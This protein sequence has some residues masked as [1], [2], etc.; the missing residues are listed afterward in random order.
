MKSKKPTVAIVLLT[1]NEAQKLDQLLPTLKFAD[2][3]ILIDDYSSDDTEKIAK[4]YKA[5][6]YKR[7]LDN[8]F[9][10]QRN[11]GLQVAR[12]DWVLFI[13]PDETV[14][15]N[16]ANEIL[17]AI[18]VKTPLSGYQIR[19]VDIFLNK[20]LLHGET[21]N[22]W[23]TR[24]GKRS[25]GLWE[26]QVHEIWQLPDV[27]RLHN[28]IVHQAHKNFQ[29]LLHKVRRYARIEADYRLKNGEDFSL[30]EY[31]SYPIGKWLQNYIWKLGFLDGW[32]GFLMALGMSYHS[33]LCRRNMY[34]QKYGKF[35]TNQPLALMWRWTLL[36]IVI[37]LALGQIGRI[38]L[39]PQ[40]AGYYFEALMVLQMFILLVYI[41][42]NK[43]VFLWPVWAKPL[44][45]LLIVMALSLLI[46]IPSLGDKTFY[47]GLYA[48][49][50]G[51]YT[52]WWL[53][54]WFAKEWGIIAFPYRRI[55][56]WLGGVWAIQGIGQYFLVPDI[57]WLY[58]FGWDDHYFR[59]VGFILDPGFFG[60]LLVL[61]LI[62]VD[63]RHSKRW[64][65]LYSLGIVPLLLTYSR[66]SYIAYAVSIVLS[67]RALNSWRFI[68]NRGLLLGLFL[69]LLPRPGGEGVR[70]ERTY[71][72]ETRI[73][74]SQ[75]AWHLFIK[76]PLTGIGF[77]AYR[78]YVP[79]THPL[80][81]IVHPSG[82][83]NSW[84]F[85]LAT[86]GI[87]GMAAFIWF[88]GAIIIQHRSHPEVWISLGT[89]FIS[90]FFNNS[91]FY[92]FVLAWIGLLIAD[93][94]EIHKELFG[95]R[96]T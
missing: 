68:R 17:T 44:L 13:D 90:A 88:W 32:P 66:A 54:L 9:A 38:Q 49:R 41:I 55:L 64:R 76:S 14:S 86:L 30:F 23:L 39:T 78:Y 10:A 70:L 48:V 59:A 33:L 92:I 7:K 22:L 26:R 62:L 25:A 57:R 50:W 29:V 73:E 67:G 58:A 79:Q 96:D 18:S 89:I 20:T 47:A 53:S 8:K 34:I 46:Q 35:Q 87:C 72:I 95:I 31:I 15:Q 1:K 19:R 4:K 65:F 71:S 42:R 52:V 11:Y 74:S 80:G 91:L 40:V 28:P 83:D 77:N 3:L 21:G 24:L 6:V 5:T 85:I 43:P 56:L 61:Y 36:F 2:E 84:L 37:N 94:Y 51:L 81:F 75:S 82:P 45:V 16:L 12:T 27:G 60:L 63:L 69:L 93:K